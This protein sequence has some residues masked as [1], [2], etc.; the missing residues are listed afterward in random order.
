MATHPSLLL[1]WVAVSHGIFCFAQQTTDHRISIA[2]GRDEP[3]GFQG[4]EIPRVDW[5]ESY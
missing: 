2:I 1:E 5:P 3:R 4:T